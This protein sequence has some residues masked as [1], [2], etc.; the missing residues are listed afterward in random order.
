MTPHA[1][2]HTFGPL[3]AANDVPIDVVQR[4]LG[5]RSIQTT[6]IYLQAEKRRMMSEVGAMFVRR[7]K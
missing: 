2:R 3:A 4:V 5:H 1:F 6:S 7:S